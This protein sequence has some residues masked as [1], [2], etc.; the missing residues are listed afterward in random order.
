[1]TK[2]VNSAARMPLPQSGTVSR[3]MN[4]ALAEDDVIAKCRKASVEISA[5]E[6]LPS[7]GTHLVCT[8]IGGADQIRA[9]YRKHII[10]GTVKRFPFYRARQ[11][12]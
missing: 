11:S 1:M 2:S 7:G 4:L 12:R 3:A 5:I 8:T 9:K 10:A 6:I